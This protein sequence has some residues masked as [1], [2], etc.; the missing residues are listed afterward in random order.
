V[1][2]I[3][4]KDKAVRVWSEKGHNWFEIF[5]GCS[6]GGRTVFYNSACTECFRDYM[7]PRR[8]SCN[9]SLND[10][11][12]RFDKESP[13]RLRRLCERMASVANTESLYDGGIFG[14]ASWYSEP[15][16]GISE[17]FFFLLVKHDKPVSYVIYNRLKEGYYI[18]H[19][20]YTVPYERRK[21][22]MVEL[23]RHSLVDIGQD[24][25]SIFHRD[26]IMKEMRELWHSRFG[27]DPLKFSSYKHWSRFVKSQHGS[28][29]ACSEIH[30]SGG[31]PLI[32]SRPC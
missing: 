14:R 12:H 15:S 30:A 31:E 9:C 17:G 22:H 1:S 24:E 32:P 19:H 7:H 5:A 2:S 13:V 26:P 18:I 23:L 25:Y 4:V 6:D 10:G 3:F 27:V 8:H 16:L 29:H 11:V 21:G 20:T 28:A